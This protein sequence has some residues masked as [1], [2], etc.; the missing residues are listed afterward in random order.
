[1]RNFRI[2][3]PMAANLSCAMSLKLGSMLR[4]PTSR[5]PFSAAC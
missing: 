3:N 2:Q 1:M 5:S 4:I